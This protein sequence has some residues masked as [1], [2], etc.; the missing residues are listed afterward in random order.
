MWTEQASPLTAAAVCSVCLPI[1]A[2]KSSIAV[3]TE[4]RSPGYRGAIVQLA[5]VC[6]S[7]RTSVSLLGFFSDA[8]PTVHP[9]T[10]PIPLSELPHPTRRRIA[11]SRPRL[12]YALIPAKTCPGPSWKLRFEC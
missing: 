7:S 11:G 2:V 6:A 8:I 5:C 4:Q 9:S 1:A 12:E 3:E 10:P